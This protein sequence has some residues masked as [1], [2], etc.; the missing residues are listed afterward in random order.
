MTGNND[1]DQELRGNFTPDQLRDIQ[2]YFNMRGESIVEALKNYLM[3]QVPKYLPEAHLDAA[4]QQAKTQ[5]IEFLG[6]GVRDE[7]NKHMPRYL[8]EYFERLS[9]ETIRRVV[10][11]TAK[12]VVS[13]ELAEQ[14]KSH[15]S[16]KAMDSQIW[17]TEHGTPS[18][19]LQKL[20][21]DAIAAALPLAMDKIVSKKYPLLMKSEEAIT[22]T[23][24]E[25]DTAVEG[26][27]QRYLLEH[28]LYDEAK[29]SEIMERLLRETI[30]SAGKAG[31]TQVFLKGILHSDDR[32][33]MELKEGMKRYD[34]IS[35]I[36][37]RL[38]GKPNDTD[39]TRG[40]RQGTIFSEIEAAKNLANES[41]ENVSNAIQDFQKQIDKKA[42]KKGG[43]AR[44]LGYAAGM[45]I[46]AF[47][48]IYAYDRMS[49]KHPTSP[50]I[51]RLPE[52]MDKMEENILKKLD[53]RQRAEA[54]QML[55]KLK[56]Y[57]ALL[58]GLKKASE[59]LSRKGTEEAKSLKDYIEQVSGK[60]DM[61][62]R[63][64]S[65]ELEKYRKESADE[66][67]ATRKAREI[68][69]KELSD[70]LARIFTQLD[71]YRAEQGAA[72]E[73]AKKELEALYK[74]LEK[75]DKAYQEL[76]AKPA[77]QETK[78]E[79]KPEIKP[80][81]KPEAPKEARSP[82]ERKPVKLDAEAIRKKWDLYKK[83]VKEGM[84]EEANKVLD[85]ILKAEEKPK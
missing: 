85:E 1:M 84:E 46:A 31:D 63:E 6:K 55:A 81:Q 13:E 41:A 59:E 5:Y 74:S 44:F 29:I 8:N 24:K 76:K 68:K 19:E 14:K 72:S 39:E 23:K 82:E 52:I 64:I 77:V 67:E 37:E 25:I 83:L 2:R 42:D 75:L 26:S 30:V 56:Q 45:A 60:I 10:L 65:K 20:A 58:E 18:P 69:D 35:E 12:Q 53:A 36:V 32:L 54:E 15:E 50:E 22:Q 17:G 51:T 7:L 73:A 9:P 79:A 33:Q 43:F 21:D 28:P 4:K 48:S 61:D 40:I 11:S 70:S 78:P 62:R 66:K 71:K 49:E 47:G 80:E 38:L 34:G 57:D 27:M 16:E 3:E